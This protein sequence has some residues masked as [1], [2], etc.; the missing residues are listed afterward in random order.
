MKDVTTTLMSF[1][2]RT[3]YDLIRDVF[4]L[5]ELDRARVSIDRLCHDNF[6]VNDAA[7]L[8]YANKWGVNQEL[9]VAALPIWH[10][11]ALEVCKHAI[12]L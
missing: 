4:A 6:L 1:S 12:D 7:L 2:H 8:I 5:P 9:S 11:I 3:A 10:C